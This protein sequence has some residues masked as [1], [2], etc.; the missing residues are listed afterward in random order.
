M[1][2]LLWFSGVWCHPCQLLKPNLEVSLLQFRDIDLRKIDV[3]QEREMMYTY[4]VKSVPTLILMDQQR[5][6]I[7]RESGYMSVEQLI[8]FL[9]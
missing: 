1:R 8:R 5:N 4:Q 2:T 7:K 9:S 3:E 6:I